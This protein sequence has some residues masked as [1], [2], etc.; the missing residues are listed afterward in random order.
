MAA[1]DCPD[2]NDK[3]SLVWKKTCF[4]QSYGMDDPCKMRELLVLSWWLFL[5]LRNVW[6]M[7]TLLQYTIKT[8]GFHQQKHKNLWITNQVELQWGTL[9]SLTHFMPLISFDTPWKHQ[10]TRGFLMFSVGIKRD[11]WHE[12]G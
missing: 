8:D 4:V 6:Q 3:V 2:L 11:Q 7:V 5:S 12:M 10:K 1:S 9:L